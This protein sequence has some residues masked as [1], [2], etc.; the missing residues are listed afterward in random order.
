MF[1]LLISLQFLVDRIVR[2]ICVDWGNSDQL[3]SFFSVL[4]AWLAVARF[5]SMGLVKE[6]IDMEEG[7][8]EIGMGEL[9]ATR[10]KLARSIP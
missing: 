1:G 6:G 2:V 8:L 4:M 10:S 7:T 9:L 5:F 3:R